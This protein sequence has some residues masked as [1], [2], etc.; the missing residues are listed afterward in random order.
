M[1]AGAM[2]RHDPRLLL[3]AIYST[4]I[5][6]VTEVEVLRALG[7]EPTARSWCAAGRTPCGCCA[8]RCSSSGRPDRHR[9]RSAW[10][11]SS[12][13]AI[14]ACSACWRSVACAP[15]VAGDRPEPWPSPCVSPPGLAAASLAMTRIRRPVLV[16]PPGPQ[17]EEAAEED[18]DEP[19]D[20]RRG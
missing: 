18:E 9:I 4:V 11:P 19:D 5:G 13:A 10:G 16:D 3:L 8:R 20:R 15:A 17:H 14:S 6:M 2:R 7:E 1:D 12:E